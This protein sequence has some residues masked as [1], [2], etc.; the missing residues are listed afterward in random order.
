MTC[1]I[2]VLTSYKDS[3]K[4][5]AKSLHGSCIGC[6]RMN[7]REFLKGLF[8]TGALIAA[9]PEIVIDQ[10]LTEAIKLSD[11]EFVTYVRWT[12]NMW[13]QNPAY[14]IKLDDITDGGAGV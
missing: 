10:F 8:A 14:C 7:R 6:T 1:R 9:N 12:M 2:V 5:P 13:V 11:A 4:G 3:E